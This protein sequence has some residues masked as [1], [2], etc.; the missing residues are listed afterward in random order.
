[1][2]KRTTRNGA[3]G[4]KKQLAVLLVLLLAFALFIF[5]ACVPPIE[6]DPEDEP[7]ANISM[8]VPNG[9]F[10]NATQTASAYLK[11]TV[12]NWTRTN[13][14]TNLNNAV[15]GVVDMR[16]DKFETHFRS[17]L[18][19]GMENLDINWP[20]LAPNTPLD[21]DNEEFEGFQDV[22]AAVIALDSPGSIYYRT[23]SS[24]QLLQNRYYKLT[25]DVFTIIDILGEEFNEDYSGAWLVING[26][27]YVEFTSIIANDGWETF[28]VYIEANNFENRSFFVELWL[29]HGPQW[30]GAT[31]NEDNRNK[32]M[33]Q[34]IVLFDNIILTDITGPENDL[35]AEYN[36]VRENQ[37]GGVLN[38]HD[39]NHPSSAFTGVGIF[40]KQYTFNQPQNRWEY[41]DK[42]LAIVSLIFPDQSFTH[43]TQY[44]YV[45]PSSTTSQ[46]YYST[47][48]GGA[49]NWRMTVGTQDAVTRSDFPNYDSQNSPV[50]IFD[51]S[52]LWD[53]PK[54]FDVAEDSWIV[55]GVRV[56]K[57]EKLPNDTFRNLLTASNQTTLSNAFIAPDWTDFF[58]IDPAVPGFLRFR[59]TGERYGEYLN[60][61]TALL[62]FHPNFS[63]SAV[64]YR[65]NV[66]LLV[67]QGLYYAISVWAYVW[68]PKYDV[69]FS[70]R[71]R[72]LGGGVS[73]SELIDKFG[74][75][76]MPTTAD[77]TGRG[78]LDE[79]IRPFQLGIAQGADESAEAFEARVVAR[80]ID[81]ADFAQVRRLV[82]QN[83]GETNQAYATR[84][85]GLSQFRHEP[86][87]AE[88]NTQFGARQTAYD[89][90]ASA[91]NLWHD[92]VEIF[93]T[94]FGEYNRL[95]NR[96]YAAASSVQA[97]FKLTG[98]T[99]ENDANLEPAQTSLV[100][101][102][103]QNVQNAGTP[104]ETYDWIESNGWE[105]LTIFVRGNDL[106]D[107]RV[108]LEFVFGE[109]EWTSA[110]EDMAVGGVIFDNIE[111]REMHGND[112]RPD[113]EN[114]VN[115]FVTQHNNAVTAWNLA[116]PTREPRELITRET[117]KT[118]SPLSLGDLDDDIMWKVINNAVV[119]LGT[120]EG[121]NDIADI[122]SIGELGWSF[123]FQDEKLNPTTNKGLA[124][125]HYIAGNIASNKGLWDAAFPNVEYPI[126]GRTPFSVTIEN[127]PPRSSNMIMLQNHEPTATRLTFEHL[128]EHPN[129]PNLTQRQW[130]T[131]NSNTFRRLS[132]WLRTEDVRSGA[133]LNAR[134]MRREVDR[135]GDESFTLVTSLSNLNTQGEWTEVS[136]F[137]RGGMFR[138][139]DL[140][141]QFEFG[142]GE[143]FQI[144]N[145]V[146]GTAFITAMLW[147]TVS[148]SEFNSS[149][150][151]TFS[152]RH[153]IS[154]TPSTSN[155]VSNGLF[156]E[157][158]TNSFDVTDREIFDE[159]GM[160]VGVANPA[161]WT[162]SA[163]VTG[164][165]SPTLTELVNN[166]SG[167]AGTWML[168]WNEVR[169]ATHYF[170]YLDG[171]EWVDYDYILGGDDE[172][173]R[174]TGILVGVVR[175]VDSGYNHI[176]TT[177]R[178]S[179]Q[180]I[181]QYF[182]IGSYRVRAV[183]SPDLGTIN[184]GRFNDQ[185]LE[186]AL[187]ISAMSTSVSNVRS[188]DADLN[189]APHPVSEVADL[190]IAGQGWAHPDISTRVAFSLH[191]DTKNIAESAFVTG[192]EN[193]L[194][195]D[196]G[197]TDVRVDMGIFNY[198]TYGG[199]GANDT[200]A[201]NRRFAD[202]ITKWYNA[203]AMGPT[204]PLSEFLTSVSLSRSQRAEILF[205]R[206]P[207]AEGIPAGN[208]PFAAQNP[209]MMMISSN[210]Q[211]R[212][213]YT[214]AT[215]TLQ[216]NSWFMLSVW[217]YTTPGT[218]ASVTINNT[219][220]VFASGGNR[221]AHHDFRFH[222]NYDGFI[223]IDTQGEWKEFRFYMQTSVASAS[224]QLE[225][226]LGNK[227][228][229]N[230]TIPANT[231]V[232]PNI[233][234]ATLN[235][236][237]TRGTALFSQVVFRTL[238]EQQY[239]TYVFGDENPENLE[240]IPANRG[241]NLGL[242]NF[243]T[244]FVTE[245]QKGFAPL[246]KINADFG[247]TNLYTFT[248]LDYTT[249]AFD[250][251]TEN[252]VADSPLG[253]TPRDYTHGVATG[254]RGFETGAGA[255]KAALLHGVYDRRTVGQHN[256]L[257]EIVESSTF[258]TEED[259]WEGFNEGNWLGVKGDTP[260]ERRADK[261][262]I[263]TDFLAND[264]ESD[265]KGFNFL[266]MAN[267]VDN[268]QH[269]MSGST[270]ALSANNFYEITI[271]AKL[272]A[273][274]HNGHF[275][276][277]VFEFGSDTV[278][279]RIIRVEANELNREFQEF[280][281]YIHNERDVSVTNNRLF[282][283]MGSTSAESGFFKGIMVVDSVSI[284]RLAKDAEG[285]NARFAT[286][287]QAEE[288]ATDAERV[289][290]TQRTMHF[291]VEE[292]VADNNCTTCGEYPCVCEQPRQPLSP[293][294]W[295]AISSI[296]I[297]VVILAVLIAFGWRK[298]K[299]RLVRTPVKVISNVPVNAVAP[300]ERKSVSKDSAIEDDE[301]IDD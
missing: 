112:A 66:Q 77:P 124:E 43:Y 225:L 209:T 135:H 157:I 8:L 281:F 42:N 40:D 76:H 64:Q 29:G 238:S 131:V 178:T 79:E 153:S 92:N 27:T 267:L 287:L 272:L 175:A 86:D 32:R 120:G 117:F 48:V 51:M 166:A 119:N 245:T 159:N 67:R 82:P 222:G 100:K 179:P 218:L 254:G 300:E 26:G 223:E 121:L 33:T 34:G 151:G 167:F 185:D 258:N 292:N 202:A 198:E 196:T 31:T 59:L 227:Y 58:E 130:L 105:K 265:V 56:P 21:P 127:A 143:A 183:N 241:H 282:F 301:Y 296:V 291:E 14:A 13:A 154:D 165:A 257:T 73:T 149:V 217:V 224:L 242:N 200:F 295:L 188:G 211:T 155:S 24:I 36:R 93:D 162:A 251:F 85:R 269:F 244:A 74:E 263:V 208:P 16:K 199:V 81:H 270:F 142:S 102:R 136:F 69:A 164:L 89:D 145:H 45:S 38:A 186:Q 293:E 230:H 220:R 97:E 2:N 289:L 35:G 10:F 1:M 249:D 60:D 240:N 107:R 161:S 180:W 109:G 243:Q 247:F 148:F 189:R 191:R 138:W 134:L 237:F 170:I 163:A 195:A 274:L 235:K 114:H 226:W 262:G 203:N 55:D 176:D 83:D 88:G 193:A 61:A 284:S 288:A 160:L 141:I 171:A 115:V 25:I 174:R 221:P 207:L 3:K 126:I 206:D 264:R 15:M 280:T 37:R 259:R 4:S 133:G 260:E 137:V 299:K 122:D 192:A 215:T 266:M 232:T 233:P 216:A 184:A 95:K 104:E 146:S 255:G 150:S 110:A 20:G 156:A 111:I 46:F 152:T 285:T 276:E 96:Y 75:T 236:G 205:G 118:L 252:T 94:A 256:A 231:A 128:I 279:R 213:G 57:N 172:P 98:A 286:A 194:G 41:V 147:Q 294:F 123:E 239:N 271:S 116:N 212:A 50:G 44:A 103:K 30:L 78:E 68:V 201:F 268:G 12:P 125:A 7:P 187:G 113:V 23:T 53:L 278:D 18:R 9:T 139:A 173:E 108:N 49:N 158:N 54:D 90:R 129:N 144:D 132:F 5:A 87:T 101:E 297:G 197:I 71:P 253:N 99:I 229:V 72:T 204:P 181:S 106:S 290:L 214:A 283:H 84:L 91:W 210:Y 298:L 169:F 63:V 248:R 177:N 168:R 246:T 52:K 80:L 234:A 11:E 62:I 70:W 261:R 250:A 47:K 273:P 39:T 182:G 65:S 17:I 19:P 140:F 6:P 190:Q 22:N 275:A 228:G 219:S 28:E 277:L